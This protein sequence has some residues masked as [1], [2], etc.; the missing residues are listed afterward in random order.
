MLGLGA[1]LKKSGL[2]TPGIVTDSL[3]LKHNYDASSVVPISDGAVDLNGTSDYISTGFVPDYIHTNAT[4]AFWVKMNDFSSSQ[5]MGIHNNKRWYF[6]FD[7]SNLFIGVANAHNGSSLITPSPALVAGQWIHYC[8]TAIDGTATVYINGVAQGT[9]SYTQSS[10]TNPSEGNKGFTIAGRN[11]SSGVG[12]EM[13]C[14]I[15]EVVNY[16]VGLT[17]NQVKTIYN[18]RE[19][20]NHKEGIVSGNLKTWWRMGDGAEKNKGLHSLGIGELI[21]VS[22]DK[23]MDSSNNWGVSSANWS[24]DGNSLDYDGSGG[25]SS[26]LDQTYPSFTQGRTYEM[27]FNTS[28]NGTI[29]AIKDGDGSNTFVEEATYS[30]G[31]K[32]VTFI[33]P[34]DTDG[35]MFTAG[36]S[37]AAFAIDWVNVKEFNVYDMSDNTNDGRLINMTTIDFEGDTP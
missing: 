2:I 15:S 37:S 23:N 33:A 30:S 34:T 11:D 31:T 4:I 16:N 21:T 22:K 17:A 19:P 26:A 25:G 20:Y 1:T 24:I 13:N 3:A 35:L 28:A 36:A 9:M 32:T 5:V 12:S 27:K 29:L 7:T 8:V 18:G 10:S 6:G 14:N